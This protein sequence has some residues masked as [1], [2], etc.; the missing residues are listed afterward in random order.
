MAGIAIVASESMKQA[1]SRPSPPL[2][3]P[4][5]GSCS[6]QLGEPQPLLP[7]RRRRPGASSI[8]LVMLFASDRPI[9]N[10]IDR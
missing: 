7:G 8:R 2:P 9:R 6:M 4:A 5:S 3:S 1:A 10:S